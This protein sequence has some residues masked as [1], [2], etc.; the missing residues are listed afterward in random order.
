VACPRHRRAKVPSF[1]LW[2]TK[3]MMAW[4][5][6]WVLQQ[7][8]RYAPS[9]RHTPNPRY[10]STKAAV[11]NETVG[12]AVGEN[13]YR[14]ANPQVRK[15]PTNMRGDSCATPHAKRAVMHAFSNAETTVKARLAAPAAPLPPPK[16]LPRV[17][18]AQTCVFVLEES[19]FCN[20]V[21]A[22]L[23]PSIIYPAA[24]ALR[25]PQRPSLGRGSR[26]VCQNRNPS[27]AQVGDGVTQQGR[28][29]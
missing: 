2:L 14:D 4:L 10:V 16:P 7:F 8:Y 6:G 23:H 27:R 26:G 3:R 5:A 12:I 18:F 20:L 15:L 21:L 1:V 17:R 24:C 13:L 19:G 11:D 28:W 25:G 22:A 9:D 29:A